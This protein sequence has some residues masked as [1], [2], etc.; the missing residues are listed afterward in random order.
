MQFFKNIYSNKTVLLTGHTG[1]KG[2]WLAFWLHQL[3][4]KVIG[5]SL[6]ANTKPNHIEALQ[7]PIVSIIGDVR[8]GQKL[9]N[10][11]KEYQPDIVFHLAAQPLVRESYAEP[12]LTFETNVLGIVQLYE[13]IRSTPSVKVVVN[14]TTD[15]V[16]HN[17]EWIWGYRE[18]DKLGGHDPY[19]T[20]KACVE[21]VHESYKK[22][23]FKQAGILSATAR[24]GNVIGGGDW[25]K[26]RLIPD[27]I[28]ATIQKEQVAI[29]N[30]TSTRP[31]QHVLEPL[32]AYLLLGQHLLEGKSIADD[33]WNIG[34]EPEGNISVARLLGLMQK[35]W[36]QVSWLD[37]STQEKLHE[38][39]LLQ[40]DCTKAKTLLQWKPIWTLE[41]TVKVTTNWYKVYYENKS[42]NTHKDLEQYI[43]DAK[44]QHASWIS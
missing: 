20:S 7:L 32:A 4:A 16:Y 22:S 26:D 10:I 19:S 25:S 8:D 44:K 35:Y 13:A 12:V 9:K 3:G 33:S 42:L 36:E 6:E 1:F 30:P 11:C 31:W 15:K 2:S 38:A 28:K 43:A 18:N 29:R 23:Y 17:N 14:I 21:L 34:P 27:I 37:T 5:Y 40:L 24:A 41:E 39:N